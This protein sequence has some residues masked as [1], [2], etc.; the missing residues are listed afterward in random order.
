M[1]LVSGSDDATI[2]FWDIQTGECLQTLRVDRPYERMNITG[3]RGLTEA[4]KQILREL[5]AVE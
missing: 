4:Q 1:I 2:K 3:V 5:G